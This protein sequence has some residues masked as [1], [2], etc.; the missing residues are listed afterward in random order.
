ML[1][2]KPSLVGRLA[3]QLENSREVGLDGYCTPDLRKSQCSSSATTNHYSWL[4]SLGSS[5][6]R[7]HRA[8]P[9]FFDTRGA[10][11]CF[12][13]LIW[14]LVCGVTVSTV[15]LPKRSAVA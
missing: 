4:R 5:C 8:L 12:W 11:R 3:H 7:I 10:V 15:A 9:R 2:P 13:G 1:Q 6:S 14:G